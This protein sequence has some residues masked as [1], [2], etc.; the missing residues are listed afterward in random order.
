MYKIVFAVYNVFQIMNNIN[1][2]V[3]FYKLSFIEKNVFGEIELTN[4]KN[5]D[6]NAFKY[7][8]SET[9]VIEPGESIV[10]VL[11]G[12]II[13]HLVYEDDKIIEKI[14][15]HLCYKVTYTS[16]DTRII[17]SLG[18]S[19][20]NLFDHPNIVAVMSTCFTQSAMLSLLKS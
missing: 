4:E 12:E 5:I 17:F 1:N 14:N 10:I 20:K 19:A 7:C 16:E 8:G 3:L 13:P 2:V 18:T 9:I 11:L 15:N 6:L